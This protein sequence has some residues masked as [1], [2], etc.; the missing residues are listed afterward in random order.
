MVEASEK[1]YGIQ[2][3]D[4]YGKFRYYINMAFLG[5]HLDTAKYLISIYELKIGIFYINDIKDCIIVHKNNINIVK[6]MISK[7]DPR[8][9]DRVCSGLIYRSSERGRKDIVDFLSSIQHTFTRINLTSLSG[10]DRGRGWQQNYCTNP[11]CRDC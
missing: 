7:L 10:P 8:R 1:R 5:G 9:R 4:I 3:V 6:Y 2:Y 11:H